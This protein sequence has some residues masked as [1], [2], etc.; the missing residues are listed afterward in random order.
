MEDKPGSSGL[1][2]QL[3]NFVPWACNKSLEDLQKMQ[4]FDPDISCILEAKKANK[5]PSCND[6]LALSPASRHYW[7]LWDVLF[8]HDGI[9][10]KKFI[11][12]NQTD[13]HLQF[14]VPFVMKTDVL[15]EHHNS[16]ISGHLGIKKTLEKI[17]QR[18]FWYAMKTDVILH[19]KRC[20]TCAANKKPMKTPRAP[21]CSITTGAPFDVLATDYLGPLPLTERGNRYILVLTDLFSKYVEVIAVPDQSAETCASCILNEFIS[22]WGCPLNILSDQGRNY[23]SK[24][25]KELC[26]MLE[27]RKIRTSPRNPQCNG[28][29]E[30]FNK[31]LVRMIKAYLCGEQDQWDKNLGYLAGA[32]RATPSESTTLTPNLLTIG[33]EVRLP[34]ELVFGSTTT[35]DNKIVT[36]Y[37]DYVDWLRSR[38]Q[39]AHQ[40]ARDHLGTSAKRNKA[41]YDAK[42]SI[43]IYNTGDV[44]WYLNEARKPGIAPK[45]ERTY[46]GPFLVSKKIS[47]VNFKL[48]LDKQGNE[49]IVHHNKLKPYEGDQVPKWILKEQRKLNV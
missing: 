33:R 4:S 40:V 49:K 31:T 14:I 3:P 41:I 15:F 43:N 23:E 28:Q 25:F 35:C 44:V 16:V 39:K 1:Q 13:E 5:R 7:V 10:F 12:Q 38:L 21:M 47:E 30:R 22:R 24:V 37:G 17:R 26:R 34:S 2:T 36:S 32:Y 29:T 18:Y 48:Q 46:D 20:D 27:I 9:L 11:R 19:V 45:L 6:V 42:V 8:V